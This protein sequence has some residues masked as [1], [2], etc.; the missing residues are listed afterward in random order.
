MKAGLKIGKQH[1]LGLF[2]CVSCKTGFTV[3]AERF[4]EKSL[5]IGRLS[6]PQPGTKARHLVRIR[7]GI[8]AKGVQ[9][10]CELTANLLKDF[11]VAAGDSIAGA[12][13]GC[14]RIQGA[15]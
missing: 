9:K 2:L 1:Q 10:S 12:N 7:L 15:K 14:C 4:A 3:C 5:S 13:K 8:V 6:R 11:L